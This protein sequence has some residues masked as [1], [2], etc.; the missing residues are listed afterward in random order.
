MTPGMHVYLLCQSKRCTMDE[1]ATGQDL[2]GDQGGDRDY[3]VGGEGKKPEN[4]I[5]GAILLLVGSMK[6]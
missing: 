2:A 3:A 6:F 1:T 5:V 4:S